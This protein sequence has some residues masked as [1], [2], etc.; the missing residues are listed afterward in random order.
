[1]K[2]RNVFSCSLLSIA[3]FQ[4]IA[5]DI[6]TPLYTSVLNAD[7]SQVLSQDPVR[8][9]TQSTA[10]QSLET[11]RNQLIVRDSHVVMIAEYGLTVLERTAQG[12]VRRQ[13]LEFN[14]SQLN[15]DTQVFASKDGKKIVW[16]IANR[17]IEVD[18]LAD[19]TASVKTQTDSTN[20]YSIFAS[21]NQSEFV[22]YDGNSSQYKVMQV[23]ADGLKVL[24]QLPVTEEIR[25]S[26][27]LYNSQDQ[28]LVSVLNDSDSQAVT[29]FQL[30]D[31]VLNKTGSA[32][33]SGSNYWSLRGSIYDIDNARLI[34]HSYYNQSVELSID[35]VTGVP[36]TFINKAENILS[37]N[38]YPEF[39]LVMTG[40]L[41][42]ARP[43]YSQEFTIK[44]DGLKFKDVAFNSNTGLVRKYAINR[45]TTGKLE[46][47]QNS[48]WSLQQFEVEADKTVLKQTRDSKDRGLPKLEGTSG[49]SSDDQRFWVYQDNDYAVFIGLDANKTPQVLLEVPK[50]DEY[51]PPV[52]YNAQFI[53]VSAGKYLLAGTSQYQLLTEDVN[54]Q[55][56]LTAPRNWPQSNFNSYSETHV[57][58]KDGLIYL[59]RLGLSVLQIENDQLSVVAN[60]QKDSNLPETDRSA[61]RAVVELKGSLY[62]LMP[63]KGKTAQLRLKDGVLTAIKTGTMPAIQGA[64]IEGRDRVFSQN[65]PSMVLMPDSAGNL[66]VNAVSY[67]NQSTYLYQQRVKFN[68]NVGRYDSS[69]M[70]N[71]AI[72]GVWQNQALSGDC[73]D[74]YASARILSGHMLT[75]TG[76]QRQ[77]VAVYQINT[78]AYM[79]SQI[80]PIQFNQGAELNVALSGYV[81]DD[82]QS[83]LVFS[84]LSN[85]AFSLADGNKL[86]YKGLATGKGDLLLTVSDGTLQ[87]ELK[88][89]YQINAAPALLRPLPV[90]MANQNAV[91]QFDINDYIEDPEGSAV[92]FVP[93]NLQGFALS[94]TGIL[95]GTATALADVT[96]PLEVSDKAGA[97][98]KSTITIKVNAAPALTGS[99]SA[100]GKVNQSFSLDL[101][102]IITDAEKHRITLSAQGLPSGLSLNGAVISGTP[103]AAGTFSVN[104]TATDELGARSQL[105][106]SVQIA[107]EDKKGGGA[108]GFGLLALLAF[109]RRRRS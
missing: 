92:S 43:Q 70:V 10:K 38:Y 11:M 98:F 20:C 95:S 109:V 13:M 31:G 22:C 83:T 88:L 102:T 73:C 6:P 62:A 34:M 100:S 96:V 17:R 21:E 46:L 72:T 55:L 45:H 79:P 32:L 12:L 99:S 3:I 69:V 108:L 24:A 59:S 67:D 29:V 58:S 81:R 51:S 82:E 25:G 68:K 86:K 40:D 106:L 93:Q 33:N 4:A 75:F 47:W 56:K 52:P 91:L 41:A 101:S 104:V 103:T 61:I 57:R 39:N 87:T 97:K 9:T 27:M 77:Q 85:D 2:T 107:P 7:E 64:I 30:K 105:N 1:M 48:Q 65:T 8:L 26:T 15:S 60:L 36:G 35:R 54:G 76:D 49:F 89:P 71:D 78:A 42:I 90:I 74:Y 63:E 37:A 19:Y 18:I 50:Y 23:A 44:R 14:A 94:K 16:I 80:E 66:Q 5:A 53:K 28:L 84:G